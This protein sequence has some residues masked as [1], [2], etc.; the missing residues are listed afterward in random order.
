MENY[1]HRKIL[2][3]ST[4]PDID[5]ISLCLNTKTAKQWSDDVLNTGI[6]YS[7]ILQISRA[8]FG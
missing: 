2:T 3:A 1:D 8:S 4:E 6:N 7:N 5:G